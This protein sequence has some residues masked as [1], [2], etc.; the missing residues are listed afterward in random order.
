MSDPKTSA[1]ARMCLALAVRAG[2]IRPDDHH[3]AW[4]RSG[5]TDATK[6]GWLRLIGAGVYVPTDAGKALVLP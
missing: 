2:T 6:R 3:P 5:C 4:S 1:E